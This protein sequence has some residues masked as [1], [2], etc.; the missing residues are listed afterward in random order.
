MTQRLKNIT[1]V[2][3]PE[4]EAKEASVR[5]SLRCIVRDTRFLMRALNGHLRRF[6]GPVTR[7]YLHRDRWWTRGQN[8]NH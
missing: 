7:G 8:S 2:I 4:E 5:Y 6:I 1:V 3:L